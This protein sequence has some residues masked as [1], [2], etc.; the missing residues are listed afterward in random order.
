MR[1]VL[2]KGALAA[3]FL[4]IALLF[5]ACTVIE[6]RITFSLG[7]HAA[8]EAV[9]P[10]TEVRTLGRSFRLPEAPAAEA[11]WEFAG[12]TD[13]DRT[14]RAGEIYIVLGNATLTAVWQERAADPIP[15]TVTVSF[16]LGE[17]GSGAPPSAVT[18]EKGEKVSLPQ[19]HGAARIRL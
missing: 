11:G 7:E 18:C 8:Q 6:Y 16:L 15:E 14:F 3:L 2:R 10:E 13:G 17:H 9:V 12:W 1:R 4:C 19:P 5:A